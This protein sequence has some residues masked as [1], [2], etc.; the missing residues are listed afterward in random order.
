MR[1]A[2]TS[3]LRRSPVSSGSEGSSEAS[4][5]TPSGCPTAE[6]RRQAI[7]EA[8]R[9]EPQTSPA[10]LLAERVHQVR[11]QVGG[12]L[13]RL[14]AR[15][16]QR[17]GA[18]E[19]G[20]H[21][22]APALAERPPVRGLE[23]VAQVRRGEP[24]G[25]AARAGRA[26]RRRSR[27]PPRP[28]AAARARP[29]RG[30]SRSARSSRR[31]ARG[32]V[33]EVEGCWRS[34]G[35]RALRAPRPSLTVGGTRRPAPGDTRRHAAA[36]RAASAGH[37]EGDPVE[38]R[39]GHRSTLPASRRYDARA[40]PSRR[41]ARAPAPAA[42]RRAPSGVAVARHA[43]ALQGRPPRRSRAGR[44]G[45]PARPPRAGRGRAAAPP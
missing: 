44:P 22:P 4:R 11:Q 27:T 33:R 34:R 31:Q 39:A 7:T 32:W 18:L 29:R 25:G 28:R 42:E 38:R 37:A 40:R 26:P 36:G 23:R 13:P 41:R 1:S 9:N 16:Q 20:L 19:G 5:I 3:T 2:T 14:H 8:F 24:A 12:G 30:G 21:E 10:R 6:R 45:A 17:P 43:E 35:F 15:E